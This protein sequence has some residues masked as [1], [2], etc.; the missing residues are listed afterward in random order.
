M[1]VGHGEMWAMALAGQ[2]SDPRRSQSRNAQTIE[3]TGK[4][5]K[6]CFVYLVKVSEFVVIH[7]PCIQLREEPL[8]GIDR[9][10][11]QLATS[12]HPLILLYFL[13]LFVGA[14]LPQQYEYANVL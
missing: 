7:E 2:K 6:T 5:S 13:W 12:R 4:D 1:L 9:I 11:L 3:R 10:Q 14:H 8:E